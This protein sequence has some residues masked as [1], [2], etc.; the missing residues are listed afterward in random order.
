[1]Q[2]SKKR[3]RK[4]CNRSRGI[5]IILFKLT[6]VVFLNSRN[7]FHPFQAS[8][9]IIKNYNRATWSRMSLAYRSLE[10][11]RACN[12]GDILTSTEHF[13]SNSVIATLF[14]QRFPIALV[15]TSKI[16]ASM[17]D[18]RGLFL[19]RARRT[20]KCSK[21]WKSF[22][23][24]LTCLF[25]KNV[26]F[27]HNAHSPTSNRNSRLVLERY[28]TD[29][30]V[31]REKE[32]QREYRERHCEVSLIRLFFPNL[33]ISPKFIAPPSK[34]TSKS[35]E[36]CDTRGASCATRRSTSTVTLEKKK[37]Q[38]GREEGESQV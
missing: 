27:L 30:T 17:K 14:F 11:N 9:K 13:P 12:H 8:W 4:R 34:T 18:R 24:F 35:R 15:K 29:V 10:C 16:S 3:N 20:V 23:T 2:L 21:I 37:E 5:S 26:N 25:T 22:R 38:E 7:F 28:S 6:K 32:N 1:M 36:G 19:S 33:T 31:V